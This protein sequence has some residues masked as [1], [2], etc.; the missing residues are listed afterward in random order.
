VLVNR[1][2]GLWIALSDGDERLDTRRADAAA[3]APPFIV[4]SAGTEIVVRSPDGASR[5]LTL[6]SPAV[7]MTAMG[8]DWTAIQ[9]GGLAYALHTGSGAPALYPLP[10]TAVQP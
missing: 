7:G 10:S 3:F 5:S 9:T 8:E 1:E 2:D 6:P 4:Y